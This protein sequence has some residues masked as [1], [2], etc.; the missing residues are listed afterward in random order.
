MPTFNSNA[1]EHCIVNINGLSEYFLLSCDDM[2]FKDYVYP[3]FFYA[4]DGYPIFRFSGKLPDKLTDSDLT[5]YTLTLYNTAS[6]IK[7][8]YN[9]TDRLIPHHNIDAYRKSDIINC[10]KQ[11]DKYIDKTIHNC[12][13]TDDDIERVIYHLFACAVGHGHIKMIN[14]KRS[15]IEKLLRRYKLLDS[16]TF[17]MQSRRLEKKIRNRKAKLFCVNDGE[18][19]TDENRESVKVILQNLFPD[20]SEFEL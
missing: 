1:I 6:L 19:V 13:R 18:E 20:K 9:N 12:F 17:N 14:R 2:F 11:F 8:Y 10:K 3:D 4:D 5:N 7:E 16:E 15:L